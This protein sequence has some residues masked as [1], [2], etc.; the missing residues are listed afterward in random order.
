MWH[1]VGGAF[2]TSVDEKYI[3]VKGGNRGSLMKFPASQTYILNI[4]IEKIRRVFFN[5]DLPVKIEI[6]E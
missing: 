6:K 4:D 2:V 5:T 3:D 1:L